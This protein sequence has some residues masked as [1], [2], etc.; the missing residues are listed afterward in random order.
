[1]LLLV[2][3]L[4][5]RSA[6]A[7][8]AAP[9]LSLGFIAFPWTLVTYGA[10]WPNLLGVALVPAALAAVALATRPGIGPDRRREAS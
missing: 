2:R 10:L 4:V 1:M 5:G 7:A 8:L 3:T 9:V 6:G